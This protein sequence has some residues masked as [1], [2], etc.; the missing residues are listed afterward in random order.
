MK[1]KIIIGIFM[2]FVIGVG[3]ACQLTSPTPASWSGTPTARARAL[4]STAIALTIPEPDILVSPTA[5]LQEVVFTPTPQPTVTADGPWLVYP[6]PGGAGL[7]AYDIEAKTTRTINL[8]EPVYFEDLHNGLSPDGRQLI[9]RAG[10]PTETDELALYQ[11]DVMTG[12]V[13]KISP[14]LSLLL[15]RRIVNQEGTLAF[16]IL[17]VITRQDGIAWSPDSRYLAFSA[18]LDNQ[19]SDL[20]VYDAMNDRVSRMNGLP[21]HSATPIWGLDSSWLISQELGRTSSGESWRAENVTGVRVPEFDSQNTFYLPIA[22]SQEEVFVGWL[23]AQTFVSYSLTTDGPSTL[24]RV[25]VENYDYSVI[26]QGAFDAVAIDPISHIIAMIMGNQSAP[27]QGKV[28]GVYLLRP[29]D[30]DF[31]LQRGGLWD[32]L[33]WDSGG[34]FMAKGSQGLFVISPDGQNM[35]LPGESYGDL[36][37]AGNW[38]IAW[39]DGARLYQPPGEYPLQ[40]LTEDQVDA[41]FWQP[42]SKA[43]FLH[44]EGD[45]YH[46][47]FPSLNFQQVDAGLTAEQPL[48][49]AWVP[50]NGLD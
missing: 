46:L 33:K 26:Q 41:V 28:E 19:S 8:P 6:A 34:I 2:I 5:T 35:I 15:Q 47:S 7:H 18:A 10:S 4:T 16:D 37:P 44:T 43:F 11:V 1:P 29:E 9:I 22:A 25:N 49:I 13:T 50:E 36:S 48:I 23:N 20:Y 17:E 3:L 14:L 31:Q 21:T 30:I 12:E 39:G 24:R 45:L 42:D 38:M 40:T 32:E 27:P